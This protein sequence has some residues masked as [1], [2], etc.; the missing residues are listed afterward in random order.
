MGEPR[1]RAE[2]VVYQEHSD[3]KLVTKAWEVHKEMDFA[4]RVFFQTLK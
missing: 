1:R 2:A 3:V 4:D